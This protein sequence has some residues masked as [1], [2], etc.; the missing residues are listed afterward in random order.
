[1]YASQTSLSVHAHEHVTA[2]KC[3]QA[4]E[5][6]VMHPS[7]HMYACHVRAPAQLQHPPIEGNVFLAGLFEARPVYS[8]DPQSGAK[9]YINPAAI[10]NAVL[11]TRESLAQQLAKTLPSKV[12]DANMNIMR[13]H[14]ETHTYVSGTNIDVKPSFKTRGRNKQRH[15]LQ[16]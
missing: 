1:M 5:H 11:S 2:R 13:T 3:R 9:R 7:H 12:Q 10:A 14:L 16:Q 8:I 15:Q 4:V 6:P